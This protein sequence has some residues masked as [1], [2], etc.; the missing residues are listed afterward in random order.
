MTSWCLRQTVARLSSAY[1]SPAEP[2][3]T[4]MVYLEPSVHV[5]SASVQAAPSRLLAAALARCQAPVE[6]ILLYGSSRILRLSR[7]RLQFEHGVRSTSAPQPQ[8]RSSV[9]LQATAG[10][11]LAG[12]ARAARRRS[13]C[14][15][16]GRIG[17]VRVGGRRRRSRSRH[18]RAGSSQRRPPDPLVLLAQPLGLPV[19]R[20]L[21]LRCAPRRCPSERRARV[22]SRRSRAPSAPATV[23]S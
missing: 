13:R 11:G 10:G 8:T 9:T 17:R 3:R 6:V 7:A 16:S 22:R 19:E 15:S 1:G 12:V 21:P 20:R 14:T 5:P 23:A 2:D 4:E 18:A